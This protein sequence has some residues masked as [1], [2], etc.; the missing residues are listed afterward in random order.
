MLT[1]HDDVLRGLDHCHDTDAS[2]DD[3]DEDALDV[4]VS[5]RRADGRWLAI[6]V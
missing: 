4:V 1:N 3:R 2:W 5:R 6:K